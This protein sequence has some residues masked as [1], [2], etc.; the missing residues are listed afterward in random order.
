[1]FATAHTMMKSIKYPNR[2]KTKHVEKTKVALS[3][4]DGS[5]VLFVR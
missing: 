1:M 4:F 5:A 2:R 3:F